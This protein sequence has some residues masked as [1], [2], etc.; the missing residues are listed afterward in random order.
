M[1]KVRK[2]LYISGR[3]QGVTFRAWTKRNAK[4]LGLSGWVR[5]LKDGR[6]E[7]VLEGEKNKVS[8]L[9][10]LLADG[11]LLADVEKLEVIDEKCNNTDG[12]NIQ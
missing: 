10:D 11:P 7:V 8:R 5:N 2:H 1:K 9:L 4:K 3:V 12:F 6:V